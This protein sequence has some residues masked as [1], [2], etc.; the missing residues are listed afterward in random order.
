ME[1]GKT[2]EQRAEASESQSIRA[3]LKKSAYMFEHIHEE[4]KRMKQARTEAEK[5]FLEK[6][7]AYRAAQTEKYVGE[8][9]KTVKVTGWAEVI[10][11]PHEGGDW[12]YRQTDLEGEKLLTTRVDTRN[13]DPELRTAEAY[14]DLPSVLRARN[15]KGDVSYNIPLSEDTLVE[16]IPEE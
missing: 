15:D 16:F 8:T 2:P 11:R 12:E 4:S 7:E 13:F 1:H 14:M 5:E 3:E 10:I 6:W 9:G